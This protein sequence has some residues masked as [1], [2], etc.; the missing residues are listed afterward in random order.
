MSIR[1]FGR[2]TG[3]SRREIRSMMEDGVLVGDYF[4]NQIDETET[5]NADY[6]KLS[7]KERRLIR[8]KGLRISTERRAK[9]IRW[10]FGPEDV[11][12]YL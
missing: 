1:E 5:K 10:D 7:D 4:S 9:G 8:N 3:T 2:A 6:L 12:G 11:P